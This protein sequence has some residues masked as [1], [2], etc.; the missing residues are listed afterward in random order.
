MAPA[1]SLLSPTSAENLTLLSLSRHEHALDSSSKD[2]SAYYGGA[3]TVVEEVL[4]KRIDSLNNDECL[5]GE[6]DSFFVADLGYVYRQHRRWQAELP[7]VEPFYAVK[8]NG[9]PRVVK[10]LA[11]LGANFDCASK[12]EIEAVLSLGL[13][14]KRIVYANPCKTPSHL[15]YAR[16][17]GVKLMTFDNADELHKVHRYHPDAKLL[18]RIMTDDSAAVCQ[19][20]VKFGAAMDQTNSL[21][22]LA[23][24]L[25]LNVVGVAFHVGSG[26][27]DPTAFMESVANARTVFD[28]A[29]ALGFEPNVLDIGGGFEDE[30]FEATAR[31]LRSA[32]EMHFGQD[33]TSGA[34]RCIAEPGRYYVAN[35]FT[36]A[37][38]VIGRRFIESEPYRA[39]LYLNDGVYGNLNAILFDHQHPTPRV[40]RAGKTYYYGLDDMNAQGRY[41][42]SVFG[43]TCDGLDCISSSCHLPV[44]V[45]VG[46]W[47]Y[48]ANVGAYTLAAST[49]FNGFGTNCTVE[50]V[51]SEPGVDPAEFA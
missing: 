22:S 32:L 40:L 46:D 12:N 39:R 34:V 48:F 18:L 36:L 10:L 37:A 31:V 25:G 21:L 5:P 29:Q 7:Q 33:I 20:S 50:Y 24:E 6:D 38:G 9:D 11:T 44:R 16:A 13:E 4:R 43:P 30:T 45:D 27:S 49:T 3:K 15:R 28:Q 35:A 14:P 17:G 26:S 41:E 19:L 51:S 47:I 1:P 23:R 42:V 8:C 2:G